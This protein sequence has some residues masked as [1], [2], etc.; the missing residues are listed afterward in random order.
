LG[1]LALDA[2][3]PALARPVTGDW[4]TIGVRQARPWRLVARIASGFAVAWRRY[5]TLFVAT[6]PAAWVS[7]RGGEVGEVDG[8]LDRVARC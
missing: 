5:D 8:R 2:A 7:E 6:S 3:G 4:A 1:E